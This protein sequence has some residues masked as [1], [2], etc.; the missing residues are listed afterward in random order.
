MKKRNIRKAVLATLLCAFGIC[1]LCTSCNDGETYADMK[2]KERSAIDNFV[3]DNTLC[4]PINEISE[5]TFA[6][7]GY[8]TNV[9]R[10]EFVKFNSDG[11]YMQIIRQGEGQTMMEMAQERDEQ[12]V[13]KPV[14]CRFLE[15]DIRNA[16]MT[17]R[18]DLLGGSDPDEMLCTY[19]HQGRSYK[20][21]FTSGYMK[22]K[23][24][25]VVP[26]GWL[27]PLDYV[28]L[29]KVAGSEAKVRL[30]VPH[31]SGT[32]NAASYVLPFYYEI[33]YQLP[34]NR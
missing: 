1:A 27:K 13:S 11:I 28:K 18:N 9:E 30:I 21:S 15:Y 5:S 24:G 22:A 12:T 6:A 33:T 20:A 10:N 4:G 17:N 31:T 2:K 16:S 8:T 26:T 25:S 34:P 7:Q 14:L 23:Y 19:S 32:A 3:R 29:T